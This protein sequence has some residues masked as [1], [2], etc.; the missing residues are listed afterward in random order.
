MPAKRPVHRKCYLSYDCPAITD[1][2]MMLTLMKKTNRSTPPYFNTLSDGQRFDIHAL[3]NDFSVWYEQV[4]AARDLHLTTRISS[5]IPRHWLG[6]GTLIKHIFSEMGNNSLLY[7]GAGRVLLEVSA[8]QLAGRRYAICFTLTL[9][10]NGIPLT[11]EAELFRPSTELS[12]KNGFRL[13]SANLYYARMIARILGGDI[14]I[15]NRPG[16]GTQYQV[17]IRL[18]NIPV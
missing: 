15:K 12:S 14:R 3:I 8:E 6:N 18:L 17:E 11:K 4:L 7:I 10:G 9:S 16:F 1:M 2:A 13:R 5:Q